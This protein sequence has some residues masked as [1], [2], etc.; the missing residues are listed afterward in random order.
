MNV[1][2]QLRSYSRQ[3]NKANKGRELT[4]MDK[5]RAFYLEGRKLPK[6]LQETV[7]KLE[8]AN[9]LLCGGYSREQAVKF[10][11]EREKVSKS[12]AYK[13]V[14]EALDLFGDVA[15]S[16]KEGLRHIVT[17]GLMQVLNHAKAAK[18]LQAAERI[19][20]TIARINGLYNAEGSTTTMVGSINVLFTS[21][22][23][24]LE[25]EQ[26][27]IIDIPHFQV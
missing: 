17:E 25:E 16:S 14:R 27:P 15:K 18:D 26:N 1:T 3:V 9:G 13:I 11:V 22:P 20:G 10:I 7:E 2:K 5:I 21:D 4:K 8:R 23:S 12:Q 6:S 19:Y 24:V